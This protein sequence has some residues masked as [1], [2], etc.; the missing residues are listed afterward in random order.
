MKNQNLL[1]NKQ[2]LLIIIKILNYNMKID[3]K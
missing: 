2:L 3:N 1:K